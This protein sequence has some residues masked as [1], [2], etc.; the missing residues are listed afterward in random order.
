MG[1][2]IDKNGKIP[3]KKM[4]GGAKFHQKGTQNFG[5]ILGNKYNWLE[6]KFSRCCGYGCNQDTII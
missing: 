6:Q 3:Y 1:S 5:L 2:K 4:L